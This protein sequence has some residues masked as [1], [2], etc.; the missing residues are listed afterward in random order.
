M[1]V[2]AGEP[3]AV[4]RATHFWNCLWGRC[5]ISCRNTVAVSAHFALLTAR[6]CRGQLFSVLNDF[7]LFP[8]ATEPIPLTISRLGQPHVIYPGTA[9]VSGTREDCFSGIRGCCAVTAVTD[10]DLRPMDT[11]RQ[12]KEV[13]APQTVG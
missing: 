9:V 2:S 5:S 3:L 4:T 13:V 10:N 12:S 7:K 8:V 6:A 1:L 11:D